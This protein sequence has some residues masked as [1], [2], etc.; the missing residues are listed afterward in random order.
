MQTGRGIAI[1]IYLPRHQLRSSIRSNSPLKYRQT[2]EPAQLRDNAIHADRGGARACKLLLTIIRAGRV[3]TTLRS[4]ASNLGPNLSIM[5]IRQDFSKNLI[6][7]LQTG[8]SNL[9]LADT[10]EEAANS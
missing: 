3:G 2:I 4:E 10:N 1:R 8:A 6:N 5:P 7:V 9:T